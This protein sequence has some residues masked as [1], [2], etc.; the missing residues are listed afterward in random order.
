MAVMPV[1]SSARFSAASRRGSVGKSL[2]ARIRRGRFS[3]TIAGSISVSLLSSR[4]D[5][6]AQ[7][8]AGAR[9]RR[10]ARAR[11]L[12]A[13]AVQQF[14]GATLQHRRLFVRVVRVLGVG[15]VG[16]VA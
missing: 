9:A 6:G 11:H 1:N 2:M 13:Q 4:E 12:L 5:T 7:A 16:A 10:T 3:T 14:L 8:A 15:Q